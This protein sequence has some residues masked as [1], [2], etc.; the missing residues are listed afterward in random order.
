MPNIKIKI[1]KKGSVN[2]EVDGATGV[3][4]TDLTKAFE[5]ELG[6]VTDVQQKPE[7]Y[8]VIDGQEIH[9]NEGNE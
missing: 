6:T 8:H 7:Y 3:T 9:V 5:T 4:C 2:L 1:D